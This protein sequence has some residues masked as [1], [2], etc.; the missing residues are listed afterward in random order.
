MLA[1]LVGEVD[2]PTFNNVF[3]FGLARDSGTGHAVGHASRRR[4]YKLAL[5][6]DR[7]SLLDVMRDLETT[8]HRLA[9]SRRPAFTGHPA[10]RPERALQGEIEELGQGTARTWRSTRSATNWTARFAAGSWSVRVSSSRVG[11]WRWPA[12]WAIA[13]APHGHRRAA[14]P[15][16][17]L[18]VCPTTRWPVSTG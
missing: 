10:H 3:A 1:R 14:G 16:V 2:E 12:R 13:G 4:T 11:S 9:G 18:R 7:V 5:G 8:R 6:L 17:G 15:V